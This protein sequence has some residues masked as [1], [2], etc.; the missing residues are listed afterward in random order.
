MSVAQQRRR[1]KEKQA[2]VVGGSSSSE[3]TQN[4]KHVLEKVR[5]RVAVQCSHN[6]ELTAAGTVIFIPSK[7]Q[8][9][10]M[11]ERQCARRQRH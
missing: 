9:A 2:P 10:C 3:L 5:D 8:T 11:E 4:V 6:D 1:I 7:C